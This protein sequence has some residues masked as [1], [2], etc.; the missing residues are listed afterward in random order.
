LC[1]RMEQERDALLMIDKPGAT[2]GEE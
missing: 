2:T 1:I